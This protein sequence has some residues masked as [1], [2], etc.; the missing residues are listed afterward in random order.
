[1]KKEESKKL[2][3]KSISDLKPCYLFISKSSSILDEKISNL[4]KLLRN[5]INMDTDFNVFYGAEEINSR[6]FLNYCNTP[7]F[8]SMR[9]VAVIKDIDKAGLDFLDTLLDFFIEYK[10][11]SQE[12][13]IVITALK[14]PFSAKEHDEG[15]KGKSKGKKSKG[16]TFQEL[17][18]IISSIGVIETLNVPASSS[19]K[20][21]LHEKAELDGLGFTQQSANRFIENVNFDLSLLKKEYEKINIYMISE[22]DKTVNEETVNR[23]VSRVFEMK[24]FDLVDFIGKRDKNNALEAL[25]SVL[26]E[27]KSAKDSGQQSQS[28]ISIM[29]LITLLHRMFKAFLYIKTH[30]KKDVLLAYVRRHLGHVPYMVEKVSDNYLKFSK[31]YSIEEIIKIF[32]ILNRYD[33]LL[34]TSQQEINKGLILKFISEITHTKLTAQS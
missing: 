26:Y 18:D 34:R 27:K 13:V 32:D 5:Q 17:I 16:K 21:W 20:K 1:M 23:L 29:G 8:F 22:K 15:K 25:K 2:P 19:L 7:S 9:K 31:N 28:G 10:E 14:M 30:G 6:D 24:I 33:I 12:T 3:E 4:K 11:K